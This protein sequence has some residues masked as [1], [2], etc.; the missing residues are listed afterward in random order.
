MVT[1]P[2]EPRR[3]VVSV[4]VIVA[5][6]NIE[7]LVGELVA[8]AGHRPVY[9]A[10]AGAAGDSIRRVRPDV[11]IVDIALPLSVV[12]A[13]LGAAD[14]VGAPTVLVSSSDSAVDL[15]RQARSTHRL[16]FALPGGPKPLAIVL[17]RALA[18]RAA[19]PEI[20]VAS[21]VRSNQNLSIEPALCAALASIARATLHAKRTDRRSQAALRAA[22]TDY[23]RQL[24]AANVPIDRVVRLVHD[25]VVDCAS[26]V[27]AESAMPVLLLESEDWARRAY[28]AAQEA[29]S[30]SQSVS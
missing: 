10:T 4:L 13:C 8:Y 29:T 14:E 26:V 7:A 22:V 27:G 11:A 6:P 28:L 25:V 16:Y 12:Q 21:T 2:T 1:E 18:S 15:E 5:D 17:D 3:T 30:E 23:A 20:T 24:S 9:D 19:Q